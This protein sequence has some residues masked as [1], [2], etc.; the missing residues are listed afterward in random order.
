MTLGRR[1]SSGDAAAPSEREIHEA[2]RG[3]ARRTACS[4]EKRN[5]SSK[6]TLASTQKEAAVRLPTTKNALPVT[7]PVETK[8]SRAWTRLTVTKKS[9][10]KALRSER[11]SR[12]R[13]TKR[14]ARGT[15][16]TK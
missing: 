1:R 15:A 13:R 14:R 8:G 9:V 4:Q 12:T 5:S 10:A 6:W 3:I 7:E 2:A 11:W 16:A